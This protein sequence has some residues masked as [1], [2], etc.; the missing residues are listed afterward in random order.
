MNTLVLLMQVVN[1]VDL[2]RRFIVLFSTPEYHLNR[3]RMDVSY[4]QI[5]VILNRNS[6]FLQKQLK[7]NLKQLMGNVEYEL[8]GFLSSTGSQCKDILTIIKKK[9]QGAVIR[10]GNESFTYSKLLAELPEC[11]QLVEDCLN[12]FKDPKYLYG[13]KRLPNERAKSVLLYT[14]KILELSVKQRAQFY[15]AFM[16]LG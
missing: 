6:E 2:T 16:E 3:A 13:K 10:G 14:T 15:H 11:D 12:R 5:H 9:K 1:D 4:D 7:E 8:I